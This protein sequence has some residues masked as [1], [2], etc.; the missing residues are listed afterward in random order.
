M[1]KARSARAVR[2]ARTIETSPLTVFTCSG[3]TG[4]APS[5]EGG[6]SSSP[7]SETRSPDTEVASIQT[8]VPGATPILS[9]HVKPNGTN[10]RCQAAN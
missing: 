2:A 7:S 6:W 8:R 9:A 1:A 10:T 5:V 4:P 3:T